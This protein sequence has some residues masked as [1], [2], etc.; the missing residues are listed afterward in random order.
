MCG[1]LSC[2]NKCQQHICVQAI[3][4]EG[5]LQPPQPLAACAPVQALH[6]VQEVQVVHSVQAVQ[7]VEACATQLCSHTFSVGL[8]LEP[9][10]GGIVTSSMLTPCQTNRPKRALTSLCMEVTYK[11]RL[12]DLSLLLA[13]A[14][15]AHM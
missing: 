14:V 6:C 10:E 11:C 4:V 1:I 13:L 12:L 5:G 15:F 9:R 7:A 2:F 3:S 8:I